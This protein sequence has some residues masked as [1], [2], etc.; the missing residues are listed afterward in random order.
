M[1]HGTPVRNCGKVPLRQVSWRISRS[2]APTCAPRRQT[3]SRTSR[4]SEPWS[5]AERF[6]RPDRNL[7]DELSSRNHIRVRGHAEA[8]HDHEHAHIIGPY[9]ASHTRADIAA[10]NR[11]N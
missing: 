9:P 4:S 2:S 5:V 6:I 3:G 1:A 11:G 8:D 10:H 7:R